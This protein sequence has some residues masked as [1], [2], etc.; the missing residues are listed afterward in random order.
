M[1]YRVGDKANH[2]MKGNVIGTVVDIITESKNIPWTSGGSFESRIY[3]VLEYADGTREKIVKSDL[4]K[5][6]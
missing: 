1:N 5:V 4:I 6:F 2:F 3:I